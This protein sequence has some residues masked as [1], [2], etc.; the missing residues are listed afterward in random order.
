MYV[1]TS[2]RYLNCFTN[3]RYRLLYFYMEAIDS[4]DYSVG[5]AAPGGREEGTD[6][7]NIDSN[8]EIKSNSL[9]VRKLILGID[10]AKQMEESVNKLKSPITNGKIQLEGCKVLDRLSSSRKCLRVWAYS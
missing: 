7:R 6:A 8:E 4:D 9:V 10:Y 5:G 2:F 1:G 3:T